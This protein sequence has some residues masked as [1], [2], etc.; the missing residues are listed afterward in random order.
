MARGDGYSMADLVSLTGASRRH[1]QL[2]VQNGAIRP[3][4]LE[5][6]T[7]VHRRFS[8]AE[9]A[10]AMALANANFG[11]AMVAKIADAVRP[12][13]EMGHIGTV[14]VV[15][16]LPDG[17]DAVAGRSFDLLDTGRPHIFFNLREA[18]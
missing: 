4:A 11:G 9:A 1:L 5:H 14:T 17:F 10:I 8:Q 18:A 16:R 13:A 15:D 3:L 12:I 2:M 6:G 7:G